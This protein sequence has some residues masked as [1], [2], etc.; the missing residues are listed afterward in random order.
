MPFTRPT[1]SDL[2]TRARGDMAARLPGADLTLRRAATRVLA[3]VHAGAC[4][5]LHGHL[6]FLADQIL[7][8]TAEGEF[9]DRHSTLW[10]VPR[11]AATQ[12]T[13]NV[14]FTG[15]HATVIPAGTVL[16]RTD[17]AEFTT[18][19][20]ATIS[21]ATATVAATSVDFAATANTD[22]G[23]PLTLATPIAGIQSTAT[24]AAGGLSGATD[25]ETD[26]ALRARILDRIRQPPHGGASFDYVTWAKEI[27][28]VTR[29]WVYPGEQGPGTVVVRFV[30]D[31]DASLI[32]DS[33]EVATVQDY[34]DGLRPVTANVSV[35]APMAVSLDLTISGLSP[36]T[37]AVK[38]AIEAEFAD[39]LAR[40]AE[41]GGT[42][43]LSHLREAI[44]LAAGE[45]DHHLDSP[46]ADVTHTAGQIAVPGTISWA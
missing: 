37:A 19:A 2:L 12:A 4:H 5:E 46:V 35:L 3:D 21:G 44:S 20:E 1:L 22:A 33:G 7:A 8:T 42:I 13:G 11:T 36:N 39:L 28:G 26:A 14:M 16:R 27:S 6:A 30:R 10:G 34:I 17:G 24:V 40:E 9:L 15:V 31:N 41:P 23:A 32:P 18:D 25:T 43:L 38:S 45:Y 29:A